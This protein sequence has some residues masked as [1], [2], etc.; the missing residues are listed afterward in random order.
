M[1]NGSSFNGSHVEREC[2]VSLSR[3]VKG[4]LFL[5]HFAVAYR[6]KMA[7][8]SEVYDRLYRCLP[9]APGCDQC[10]DDSPCLAPYDWPFR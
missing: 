7:F 2:T 10:V 1:L 9:C 3:F 4:S 8:G 5:S 6:D